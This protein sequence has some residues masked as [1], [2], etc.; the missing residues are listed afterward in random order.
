MVVTT[1]CL[2]VI[3]MYKTHLAGSNT[4]TST[5]RSRYSNEQFMKLHQ[6]FSGILDMAGDGGTAQ[7]A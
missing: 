4:P 1:A 7:H 3:Y 2:P 6:L 5:I